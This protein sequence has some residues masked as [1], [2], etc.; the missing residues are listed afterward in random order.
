MNVVGSI[1]IFADHRG[2]VLK[3]PDGQLYI[4]S[5]YCSCQSGGWWVSI[6]PT[7]S[8]SLSIEEKELLKDACKSQ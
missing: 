4:A 8:K 6:K 1:V 3:A 5:A 2:L 7:S